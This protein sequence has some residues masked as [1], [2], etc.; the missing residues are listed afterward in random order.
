MGHGQLPQGG[1]EKHK[2]PIDRP[3]TTQGEAVV[4]SSHKD[5]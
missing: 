1:L 5:P 2:E 3:D 4:D